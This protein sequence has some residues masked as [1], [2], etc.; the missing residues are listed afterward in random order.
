MTEEIREKLLEYPINYVAK[1]KTTTFYITLDPDLR[2]SIADQLIE[3]MRPLL[4]S[5]NDLTEGEKVRVIYET[6]SKSIDYDHTKYKEGQ[7]VHRYTY[8]GSIISGKAVCF[9]IAQ[10]F[11]ILC[12][13]L[14][15]QVETVIGYG[16]DPA[17]DG[18]KHAWNIVWVDGIPYHVDLTWDL[19]KN[20]SI[21]GYFKYYLKSDAFMKAND[22]QWLEER[23][24]ACNRDMPRTGISKIPP[25]AVHHL[26]H[27]FKTMRRNLTAVVEQGGKEYA[28]L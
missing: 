12:S 22:H 6:L 17:R 4:A 18:G 9:G 8:A 13:A 14:G 7:G 5:S 19:R 11:E 10:L 27:K 23:H 16:G 1:H 25:A 24:P 3:F 20:V 15:L 26:C 2:E 21:R 28:T